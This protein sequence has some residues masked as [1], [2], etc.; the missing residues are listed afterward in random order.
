[1]EF[2]YL[3]RLLLSKWWLV[4]PTF[5]VAVAATVI[6]TLAQ[7]PVYES[8]S[9]YVVKVPSVGPDD[10]LNALGI[11]SRQTEIAETYAQ[12]GSS[13]TLQK[14]AADRLNLTDEQRADVDVESKIIPG[15]NLL[16]LSVSSTSKDLALAFNTAIGDQLVA[17]A[18][19]LYAS[20]ELAELDAPLV[21][22]TPVAPN[23][24]LNLALGVVA[25]A[26][27]AVGLG[28]A[29]GLIAPSEP[30]PASFEL[31]D[32]ESSA[33]TAKYLLMRI[34]QEV[35]RTHRTNAPLSLAVINVNH[36]GVLE[37]V[38]GSARAEA[39]RRLASLLSSHVRPEDVVARVDTFVFGI[40]MPDT[41]ESD[42]TAMI[43][44]ARSRIAV[45][46][47]GVGAAGGPLRVTPAAG[48]VE[49]S[50]ER[51]GA[52]ELLDRALQALKDA[53]GAPA[54]RTQ[55]FS[56]LAAQSRS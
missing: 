7:S 38:G 32:R 8:S 24:P 51:I 35:S 40:L 21:K 43:E 50:G 14:Q 29:A 12:A 4:I 1:M 30:R 27:L 19:A 33:F 42:A 15:T 45:P 26:V 17:Y 52:E 34:G 39:L 25:G 18:N 49:V 47:V 55:T 53:E 46:A 9:T 5:V 6:F 20:F 31:L 23:V 37:S 10:P 13:R 44:G 28:L 36:T 54:G 3:I 22:D 16:E 41:K 2:R 56:T 48:V 11:L